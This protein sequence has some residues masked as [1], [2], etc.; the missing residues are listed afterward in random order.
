MPC[1]SS[2][3]ITCVSSVLCLHAVLHQTILIDTCQICKELF[4]NSKEANHG[5]FEIK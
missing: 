2:I 3:I 4:N 1:I 5:C